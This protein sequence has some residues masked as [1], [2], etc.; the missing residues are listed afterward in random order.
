MNKTTKSIDPK[1]LIAAARIVDNH[2]TPQIVRYGCN[3]IQAIHNG[4]SPRKYY[5]TGPT[6]DQRDRLPE[7]RLLHKLFKR[8]AKRLNTGNP[9]A[10]E[11]ALHH[12]FWGHP[13]EKLNRNA[14]VIGLLLASEIAKEN[15]P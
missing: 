13:S 5:L 15:N 9:D 1:V 7:N 6:R 2:R 11:G 3:A 12:G 10:F 8:D 4:V 14:R